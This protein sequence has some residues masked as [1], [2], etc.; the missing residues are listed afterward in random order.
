MY[1]FG[2][3]PTE[4]E[5]VTELSFGERETLIGYGR[6][7]L[8]FHFFKAD[9]KATTLRCGRSAEEVTAISGAVAAFDFCVRE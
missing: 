6:F 4:N 9:L 3:V 7:V 8:P 5:R 1:N 2:S